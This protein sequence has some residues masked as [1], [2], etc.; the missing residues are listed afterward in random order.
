LDRPLVSY[1]PIEVSPE[2]FEKARPLARRLNQR[3]GDGRPLKARDREIAIQASVLASERLGE[4]WLDEI[5]EKP[6]LADRGGVTNRWAYFTKACKTGAERLG[7]D[8]HELLRC[9]F[10]PRELVEKPPPVPA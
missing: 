6:Q 2:V 9:V 1:A 7:Y 3:L 4:D 5:L 8:W 10:V